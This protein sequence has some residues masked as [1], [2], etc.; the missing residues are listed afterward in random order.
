MRIYKK[1]SMDP[2]T[3]YSTDSTGMLVVIILTPFRM[4]LNAGLQDACA[5]ALFLKLSY[6]VLMRLLQSSAVSI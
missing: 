5:G 4:E 1:Y 2:Y 6:E 3:K